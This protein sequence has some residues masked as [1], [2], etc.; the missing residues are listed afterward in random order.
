MEIGTIQNGCEY[1]HFRGR[2]KSETR[3]VIEKLEVD[4]CVS[5]NLSADDVQKNV[6]THVNSAARNCGHELK[7][8]FSVRQ[9]PE[10][11]IVWRTA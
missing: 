1:D 3:L 6:W 9:F 7:R 11:I 10:K 8:K 2:P 4:Q 5:F